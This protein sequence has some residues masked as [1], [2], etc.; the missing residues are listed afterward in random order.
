MHQGEAECY[1]LR[2]R[3]LKNLWR[4]GSQLE[5]GILDCR[6]GA[7]VALLFL[8]LERHA[9]ESLKNKDLVCCCTCEAYCKAESHRGLAEDY[10]WIL[11]FCPLPKRLANFHVLPTPSTLLLLTRCHRG[12]NAPELAQDTANSSWNYIFSGLL[13]SGDIVQLSFAVTLHVYEFFL[14]SPPLEWSLPETENLFSQQL[15]LWSFH[16]IAVACPINARRF[17]YHFYNIHSSIT[18]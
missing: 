6:E 8:W 11:F 1:S 2:N 16:D 4:P 14:Y 5:W 13:A 7:K 15:S 9:G 17:L 10:P 3:S 18:I 12:W